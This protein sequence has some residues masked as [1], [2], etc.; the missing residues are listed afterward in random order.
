MGAWDRG[1]ADRRRHRLGRRPRSPRSCRQPAARCRLRRALYPSRGH[2]RSRHPRERDHR[3]GVRQ[4]HRRRRARP[5]RQG[6]PASGHVGVQWKSPAHPRCVR[7]R[8]K[9]RCAGS[10][11][12]AR[13]GP[14]HRC[15]GRRADPR[16]LQRGPGAPSG[17]ALRRRRRQCG[18][19]QRRQARLPVQRHGGQ[20]RL[21]GC[22]R[23]QRRH[24]RVLQLRPAVGRRPRPRRGDPLDVHGRHV[25]RRRRDLDGRSAGLGDRRA[26]ALRCSEPPDRRAQGSDLRDGRGAD[27]PG[28][29]CHPPSRERARRARVA[30]RRRRRRRLGQRHRQ[31]L[32]LDGH[33]RPRRRRDRRHLRPHA[34]RRRCRRRRQAGARRLVPVGLR[35]ARE[36]LSRSAS[37]AEHGRRRVR[38]LPPTP[39]RPSG[40]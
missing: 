18:K 38:R 21:R 8:R 20:S 23:R 12:L 10:Q 36:R 7:V 6:G 1:R 30:R 28:P 4:R 24:D 34:A 33:R 3:G 16:P 2:Q 32:A 40:R 31:L 13:N 35:D 15:R 39:A 17:H 22:E 14:D 19:R 25:H 29:D 37:A 5:R 11:R 9:Q 27:E 26:G